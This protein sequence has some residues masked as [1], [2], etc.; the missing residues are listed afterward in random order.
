MHDAMKQAKDFRITYHGIDR[1]DYFQGHGIAPNWTDCAT[2][3][4]SSNREALDDAIDSLAQNDWDPVTI[5]C[6]IREQSEFPQDKPD[7]LDEDF[8]YFVSVDVR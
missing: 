7:T 3:I 6:L 2:G 1:S 4:G 5:E 8:Y